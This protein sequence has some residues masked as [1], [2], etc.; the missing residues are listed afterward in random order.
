MPIAEIITIGTEL[1]L[2]EIQDTNTRFLA[3]TLRDAGVDLYR[4]MM[5]GDNI[6]RIALAIQEA[7]QRSDIVITTGGLG[8]TI[9]DPTRQ[10]V[11]QAFGVELEFRPEFWDQILQRFQRYGR[12]PGENNKRQAFIPFG[13]SGV[14]NPVGTAPAFYLQRQS[15]MVISLPGVPREMEYL[16]QNWMMPFLKEQYNLHGTIKARVLH[17]ASI[18]ESQVDELVSDLE[19][20]ANPTVGLLAH[21][22]QVDIR[23]TA[24][25]ADFEEA[26]R[27]IAGME[28]IIRSRLGS[29]IYG[30]DEDRLEDSAVQAINSRNWTITILESGLNGEVIRRLSQSAPAL[31]SG[32]IV[33][34]LTSSQDVVDLIQSEETGQTRQVM[35]GVSLVPRDQKQDLFIFIKT[36]ETAYAINRS[37]GGPPQNASPW[38]VNTCLDIIRR[39]LIS[40]DL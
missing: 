15:Q 35:L 29:D 25:A 5:V 23:I 34:D 4:T 32:R 9:D 6:S 17:T 33:S 3:R 14:E 28:A 18:G 21:P 12:Q 36:P 7:I 30:S 31:V 19:T 8:P 11:A 2:G 20:A 13:A 40:P 22:G 26:D 24:K 27:M 10:A 16:V 1:L 37:Y 39:K 38:A